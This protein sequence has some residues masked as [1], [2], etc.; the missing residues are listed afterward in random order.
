M[1]Q[2]VSLTPV[3]LDDYTPIVGKDIVEELRAL[4]SP[5]L[6]V[7]VLM[8]SST[9]SGGGVAVVLRSL[10]PG[11][12]ALAVE[13]DWYVMEAGRPFYEVTKLLHNLLQGQDG[14]LTGDQRNLF[15]R[16]NSENAE[17]LPTDYDVYVV[18]DPQPA[19][20]HRFH[21]STRVPW[22]WR[23][24]ID[25][26]EPSAAAWAYMRGF[27]QEYDG[28]VFSLP[29]FVPQDLHVPL[30]RCVPLAIDPLQPINADLPT[31]RAEALAVG[32]GIALDR[33]LV[34]QFSRFDAWKDPLGVLEAYQL[35]QQEVPGVQL[36]LNGPAPEDDPETKEVY[37]ETQAAADGDPDVHLLL[38][39]T[40][41]EVNA[42]QRACDV[43]V[44]KSLREG[45]GLVVSEALWKYRPLVGSDLGGIRLQLAGPLEELLVQDVESCAARVAYLLERPAVRAELG[46]IGH[47]RV[48]EHFLLPRLV[49]DN[50]VLLRDALSV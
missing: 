40:P 47:R 17:A 49:R 16:V 29:E 34:G 39:S 18:H 45:F 10:I 19:A 48:R 37:R 44:Q 7:R 23:S 31:A 38:E 30:L 42:L 24:H 4:G 5:L 35:I 8:L 11:L 2:R 20:V 1:T 50:V 21:P 41:D 28:A 9:A 36:V 15:E 43:V 25:T 6:G 14:D 3:S 27:V 12:R 32:K 46:E 26:S 33:P 13:A 22:L